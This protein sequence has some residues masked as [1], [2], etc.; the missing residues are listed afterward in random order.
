MDIDKPLNELWKAHV[1]ETNL[2]SW[3]SS[4]V[5]VGIV[6]ERAGPSPRPLASDC[7][8]LSVDSQAEVQENATGRG[9]EEKQSG[10][11]A[12][13]V[14]GGYNWRGMID[15]F[16]RRASIGRSPQSFVQKKDRRVVGISCNELA[17]SNSYSEG[18][19]VNIKNVE[20]VANPGGMKRKASD[21]ATANPREVLKKKA[22]PVAADLMDMLK[23]LQKASTKLNGVVSAHLYT[24]KEIKEVNNDLQRIG[25]FLKRSSVKDLLD[26]VKWEKVETPMYDAETQTENKLAK[27]STVTIGVQTDRVKGLQK[28]TRNSSRKGKGRSLVYAL[29]TSRL[30]EQLKRPKPLKLIATGKIGM[31]YLRKCLEYVFK[32]TETK[33]TMVAHNKEIPD[34]RNLIAAEVKRRRQLDPDKIIVKANGKSYADLLRDVKSGVDIEVENIKVKSVKKRLKETY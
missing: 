14:P 23:L 3:G 25:M 5:P 26:S 1:T 7:S 11:A 34:K 17:R 32:N 6:G 10:R 30:R 18:T 29:I 20:I 21:H 9:E 19:K 27:P 12:N 8:V 33:V 13:S 22:N 4:P 28:I 15:P 24:K 16:A 2:R 31:V